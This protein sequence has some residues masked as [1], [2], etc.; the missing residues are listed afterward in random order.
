MRGKA[1]GDSAVSHARVTCNG[2]S[3]KPALP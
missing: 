3:A 1:R 2:R